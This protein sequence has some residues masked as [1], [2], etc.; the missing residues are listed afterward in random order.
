MHGDRG[1]RAPASI[2]RAAALA[3]AVAAA[4]CST[5]TPPAVL[6]SVTAHARTTT[7][8]RALAHRFAL[9][10][11]AAVR[12][13]ELA[14]DADT[15]QHLVAIRDREELHRHERHAIAVVLLEGHG[16][17][18]VAGVEREV[19]E[20][21]ILYVPRGV[22]HAFINESAAPAVAYVVYSPPYDGRDRVPVEDG[23]DD[24]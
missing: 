21:S 11:S 18:H 7:E 19:G 2:R 10:G 4:S 22:V 8:L 15:S 17:M 9:E 5:G 24:R 23:T 20:G 14:R 6:D 13:L 3:F 1:T 12:V 16:R